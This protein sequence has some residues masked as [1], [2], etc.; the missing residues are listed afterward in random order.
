MIIKT[1][2]NLIIN[3]MSRSQSSRKV[4]PSISKTP[5]C[6]TCH[7]AGKSIEEYTSHWTKASTSPGAVIT[8]PLILTSACGYCKESGHWTK[9]CPVLL[10]RKEEYG[11]NY[12]TNYSTNK[13][14]E[15]I[16]NI[17]TMTPSVS[18]LSSSS[19]WFRGPPIGITLPSS[20]I[21]KVVPL[22]K[23][24]PLHINT[25]ELPPLLGFR[26]PSPNSPP[27]G[28]LLQKNKEIEEYEKLDLK[29]PWGDDSYWGRD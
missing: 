13:K 5:F 19:S 26:P 12:S 22:Q 23:V 20:N 21:K 28:Y 4:I 16:N 15:N 25:N 11:D 2:Q 24:V 18:S 29:H 17:L 7:K 8:C 6:S 10:S 3:I 9:Y 27:P 1:N 14:L